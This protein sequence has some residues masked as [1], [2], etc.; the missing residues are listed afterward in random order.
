MK[1]VSIDDNATK[2]FRKL[3]VLGFRAIQSWKDYDTSDGK[4]FAVS[5]VCQDYAVHVAC[6][7]SAI[8]SFTY[9]LSLCLFRV[10]TFLVFLY[11]LVFCVVLA[12][13][14]SGPI[15]YLFR[16]PD[17]AAC[18]YIIYDF[19]ERQMGLRRLLKKAQTDSYSVGVFFAQGFLSVLLCA[20]LRSFLMEGVFAIVLMS[21]SFLFYYT[22]RCSMLKPFRQS[23]EE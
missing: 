22:L 7:I 2:L 6:H 9:V 18:L 10:T 17:F 19:Y 3:H 5:G 4:P 1:D 20:S 23:K 11:F 8:K 16:H 13:G 14:D 15:A 12:T 21:L